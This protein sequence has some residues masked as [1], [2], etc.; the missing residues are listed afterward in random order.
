MLSLAVMVLQISMFLVTILLLPCL[1]PA[2]IA[3]FIRYT[4]SAV[5][6]WGCFILSTNATNVALGGDVSFKAYLAAGFAAYM[7]GSLV[8]FLRW[9][10][11]SGFN[12]PCA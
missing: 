3:G 7:L 1:G 9:R 12:G 10:A 11:A 6:L 5:I 8:C 2:G 4:L